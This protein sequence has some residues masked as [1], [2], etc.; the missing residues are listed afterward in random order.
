MDTGVIIAIVIVALVLIGLVVALPKMRERGRLRQRERELE[1]RRHEVATEHRQE[2]E[3]RAERAQQAEQRARIAEHEAQ[4]E[5]AEAQLHEERASMHE[6]G[7]ADHELVEDHEREHFAGTSAVRDDDGTP[8]TD[9][10]RRDDDGTPLADERRDDE[11]FADRHADGRHNT[12]RERAD[13]LS[14]RDNE[15]STSR[16]ARRSTQ[17]QS[18]CRLLTAR[19]SESDKRCVATA[20]G[21]RRTPCRG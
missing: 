8:F 20:G 7:L 6:Q 2:A 19:R 21:G 13:E 9:D 15:V 4:R 3:T 12:I 5:R 14:T 11:T 1:Q 17:P 10:D 18:A 16:G